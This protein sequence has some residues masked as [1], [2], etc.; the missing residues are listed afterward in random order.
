M[1]RLLYIL[2]LTTTLN[3]VKAQSLWKVGITYSYGLSTLYGNKSNNNSDNGTQLQMKYALKSSIGTGIKAERFLKNNY[4]I[5][6][7]FSYTQRGA[8]FDVASGGYSPRYKLD[9]LD[10]SLG[11]KKYL[12]N[13]ET[14]KPYLGL[15]IYEATML[16]ANRLDVYSG[17]NLIRDVQNI[18]YGFNANVGYDF[19]TKREDY[20]QVNLF[21]SMGFNQV[22]KGL[23]TSNGIYGKN[24]LFGVQLA[25]LIGSKIKKE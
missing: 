6:G 16:S 5:T 23:I 1:R 18:D 17:T 15:G 22:F 20:V 13:S 7:A 21:Y 14:V 9:Y 11:I 4:L 24:M 10:V 25:Y 3:C 2:I 8:R 12:N 19:K